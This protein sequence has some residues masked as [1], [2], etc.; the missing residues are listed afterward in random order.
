LRFA[1]N[2]TFSCPLADAGRFGKG[3]VM[4]VS[5]TRRRLPA[6]PSQ[7]HLRKLA[8]RLAKSENLKLAAAQRR[9]AADHGF[10]T[11]AALMRGAEDAARRPGEKLPP[12]SDAAARADVAAVRELLAGGAPADGE[13]GEAHPPLWYACDG[14]VPAVRRIAV[15]NLLLDAGASPRHSGKDDMTPLHVAARRG[16]R[17]LV[18]LLIRRGALSW[19]PDR[20]RKRAIDYARGGEAPDRDAIVELLDRP[21]IRDRRFRAAVDAIHAGD[22]AGLERL[23]DRHPALLRERATEPDC[24]PQDYFRDPKLF[25]FI[26]NNP[27][28]MR[29]M[30]NNIV[31]IGAAMIARGVAQDDLDVA[32]GLVMSNGL[33]RAQSRQA[34]LVTLLIDAGATATPP[35][36]LVALAH[37]CV[38]PIRTLL[39]RGYALTPPI[40][41][42][43]GRDRELAALLANASSQERQDALALAVINRQVEA[44]RL[45]LDAGADVNA[46]LAVHKHSTP[47]HQAAVN[48]DS[49]MLRLLVERGARLDTRDT[50]WDGTPLQWAVHTK[51]RD[52]EAFLRAVQEGA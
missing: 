45:C 24:Y 52:A 36:V 17:A 37:R 50:L 30:P 21:V 47:L 28:L 1:A 46:F 2:D 22:L 8:K 35:A 26:A 20:R 38:A 27:T 13:R 48:D 6:R 29:R 10:A 41:A 3:F 44:A 16:P 15:A 25:W 43:I 34:E 32:L 9:L 11:W 18:E 14:D 12:L 23:L 40:A 49:A 4:A 7:E 39:D 5:E 42:A 33:S 51:Q 31:A 19:Q